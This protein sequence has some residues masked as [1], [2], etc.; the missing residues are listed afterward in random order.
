MPNVVTIQQL[1][2]PDNLNLRRIAIWLR[3]DEAILI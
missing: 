1:K 3:F 2:S